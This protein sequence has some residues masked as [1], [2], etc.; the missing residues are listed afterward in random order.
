MMAR[1]IPGGRG[2]LPESSTATIC[3]FTGKEF[4]PL[5]PRIEDIDIY[6]IAH[7]LSQIIRYTGHVSQPWSVALHSIEVSKRVEQATGDTTL[8][9][10]GLLHDASEAYLVDVPR[11]LKPF[12]QG[13]AAME[14]RLE[15]AIF[16][17]FG[18]PFPYPAIVK[19]VDTDM[20]LDEVA[21]FFQ[22]GSF[23]WRRYQI[24][25]RENHPRLLALDASVAR[26][27]FLNRFYE[28]GGRS[29][30]PAN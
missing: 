17:R 7:A 25:A 12:F 27:L 20:L 13:Y 21:N 26:F 19:Q 8:A 28:L 18:L 30:G 23:I 9:M 15:E 24:E 22:P 6:D 1:V 3:T 5:D 29:Y 4:A 14:A 2:R 11:P 16:A 10:A